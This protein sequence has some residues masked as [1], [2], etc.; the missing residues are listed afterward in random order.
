MT[1]GFL[2]MAGG[3]L[4]GSGACVGPAEREGA[5]EPP[6]SLTYKGLGL[7]AGAFVLV[8]LAT[9][10]TGP[11]LQLLG[12]RAA[13]HASPTI[14]ATF[15]KEQL[16]T[17]DRTNPWA[18]EDATEIYV[19]SSCPF[20]RIPYAKIKQHMLKPYI[21]GEEKRPRQACKTCSS[22]ATVLEACRF[23]I[24]GYFICSAAD[25]RF[26]LDY[27]LDRAEA[28][29]PGYAAMLTMTPCDLF[30]LIQGR[31][32]WLIGDSMNTAFS[33]AMSCFFREFTGTNILSDAA[34][35]GASPS[36]WAQ[37]N[38]TFCLRLDDSTRFCH[39]YA[40]TG[41]V[42]VEHVMPNLPGLGALHSDVMLVNFGLHHSDSG[43]YEDSLHLFSQY[44]QKHREQL[45]YMIWRETSPEHFQTYTGEQYCPDCEPPQKPFVCQ[46]VEG[47]TLN[48]RNELEVSDPRKE[49]VAR[50]NWRN[51]R[52]RGVMRQLAIPIMP[53]WNHSLP[54][55]QFHTHA[56]ENDMT[57]CIH[58]CRPSIF[59]MWLYLLY[60]VLKE[61]LHNFPAVTQP[62]PSAAAR[63]P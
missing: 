34:S 15:G 25:A 31:T 18:S 14:K 36:A 63:A 43:H 5:Q 57:G 48:V 10:A 33:S 61:E 4:S 27:L 24:P 23:A 50:G 7:L 2:G 59:E 58:S 62:R 55:W 20:E 22:N 30:S 60:K 9:H 52:A 56:P 41:G 1:R 13:A 53:I 51:E 35:V 32:L 17:E 38:Y 47:V 49:V 28:G 8:V 37:V 45:P 29:A 3:W 12:H 54:L 39:I 46:A 44:F 11:T 40:P 6:P 42:L 21:L 19:G 26:L 16:V